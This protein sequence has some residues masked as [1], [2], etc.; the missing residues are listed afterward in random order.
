MLTV[1]GG[2]AEFERE[3]ILARTGEGRKHAKANAVHMR[4][5]S[6]L[7]THKMLDAINRRDKS[8]ETLVGM[9][10]TYNVSAATICD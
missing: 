2:L 6:K 4:R 7:T 1:L 5:L 10:R 8:E 3:L 9:G